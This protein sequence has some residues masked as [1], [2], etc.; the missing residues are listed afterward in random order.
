MN[1]EEDIENRIKHELGNLGVAT[2]KSIA[3]ASNIEIAEATAI[4]SGLIRSNDVVFSHGLYR[5]NDKDISPLPPLQFARIME[6]DGQQVLFWLEPISSNPLD[7]SAT[8]PIMI[9]QITQ[10]GSVCFDF[11][12]NEVDWETAHK[13]LQGID[14]STA[15]VVVE[16]AR[17]LLPEIQKQMRDTNGHHVS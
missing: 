1:Y 2:A 8:Q 9:H 3:E 4:L 5:L 7:P 13:G 11:S 12:I 6:H 15:K 17:T 10:I 14:S 16:N